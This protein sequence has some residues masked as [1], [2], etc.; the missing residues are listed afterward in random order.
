MANSSPQTGHSCVLGFGGVDTS[1]PSLVF[2]RLWLARCPPSAWNDLN[3]LLHVL[4]WKTRSGVDPTRERSIKQFAIAKFSTSL[5][6]S[7]LLLI[8]MKLMMLYKIDVGLCCCL[9][10]GLGHIYRW[11]T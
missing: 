6:S 11:C 7:R 1:L 5:S 3:S 9:F 10:G 2:G 4:Q 8:A